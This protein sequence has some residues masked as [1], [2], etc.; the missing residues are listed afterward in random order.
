M[1]VEKL[2]AIPEIADTCGPLFKSSQPV[3][4]TEPETEYMVACIKH[5]FP[6]HLVLQFDC[7][8][9]LNDQLLENVLIHLELPEGFELV[10]TVPCERLEYN[11]K[12]TSYAV[13]ATPDDMSEWIGTV[14]ATLKFVVKDCDPTTGEPDSDEGYP[15]EY[16][17]EDLELAIADYVQRSMKANFG[18]AWEE[19]V[20]VFTVTTHVANQLVLTELIYCAGSRERAGGYLRTVVHEDVGGGGEDHHTVPRHAALREVG[21]G[22]RGEELPHPRVRRSVQ[23]RLP[24]V[25]TSLMKFLNELGLSGVATRSW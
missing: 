18:A 14:S 8:N 13:I 2:S 19:L 11:I 25:P 24:R 9:T 12:G 20:R 1:F 4:L 5:I 17:L 6:E 10:A 21:Q 3:E 22:P 15:D 16:V 23:V 7:T